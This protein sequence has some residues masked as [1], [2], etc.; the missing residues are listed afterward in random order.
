MSPSLKENGMSRFL[1]P[2]F[3]PVSLSYLGLL[4]F[5]D[6]YTLGFPNLTVKT[7]FTQYFNEMEAIEVFDGYQGIFRRFQQDHDLAAL[8]GGYW[9]TYV[10]QTPAQAFD[11]AN[12]NLFR[13]TFY[14]PC[15]RYLARHR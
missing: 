4:T 9:E 15:T 14:E 3:L 5:H 11:K 8:F 13:T 6:E 7:L 1:D 10:G 2:A 12:E